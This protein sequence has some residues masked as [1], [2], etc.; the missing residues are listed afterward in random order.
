MKK[1]PSLQVGDVL[2]GI[3]HDKLGNT[4]VHKLRVVEIY[5][6]ADMLLDKSKATPK[7]YDLKYRTKS[8][9]GSIKIPSKSRGTTEV[10]LNEVDLPNF[11]KIS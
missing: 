8:L 4:K 2:E 1:Q 3:P 11:P 9:N 7:D 5:C 10:V 6:L